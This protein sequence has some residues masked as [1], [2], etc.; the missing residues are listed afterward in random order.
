MHIL[1]L[2]PFSRNCRERVEL[3]D[4]IKCFYTIRVRVCSQQLQ[5]K[6]QEIKRQIWAIFHR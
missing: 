4:E 1:S 5:I 2:F 3:A 6:I